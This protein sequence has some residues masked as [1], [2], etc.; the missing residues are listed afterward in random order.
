MGGD[1]ENPNKLKKYYDS[2]IQ[3]ASK[4]FAKSKEAISKLD[5][6]KTFSKFNIK[7]V[8]GNKRFNVKIINKKRFLITGGALAVVLIAITYF[9]FAN[10]AFA[11]MINGVE[12]AKVKD[13]KLV[14]EL[15]T[16]L[17]QS[18]EK[19]N[20]AEVA[21]TNQISYQKIN[22]SKK[23]L[24]EGK[25]LE[26][27]LKKHLDYQVECAVIYADDKPIVT[28]K[29]KD[30]AERVLSGVEQYF[31][32]VTETSKIKE[33]SFSEKVEIKEEFTDIS[34]AMEVEDA[35][36]YII[37]G[38]SEVRIH[39]V[40]AGESFWSISRKYDISLEDLQKANPT[41]NPEKIK[42]G[43]ELNLVVPKSLISVKTIEEVTYT[44]KI[45][46]E[47]KLELS[48]S[49]Y[50]DQ[51]QVRVK[52]QYGEKEVKA[53]VIKINGIESERVILSENII[54]EP[55]D[56][57]LV[58][59]TKDPPPKKGTGTFSTPTRGTITSRYGYRWGRNHN[60]IDIAAPI[61]TPVK[62][63]DGGEVI[64]AGTSGGYGK[65]IKIDH[66]AGFVT[67]YGHL[68]KISVKV[69]QK[70]YKGQV[71]GAVGNTGNSTGPHLHFE[72][73][74]NGSP[75]NPSKYL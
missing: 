71:I 62:A 29:T 36:N 4:W 28:L 34:L 7:S 40:E 1:G 35:Q 44:D 63:A 43:Q 18:Y 51:T 59:G 48:S 54:K 8:A 58:K 50:K 12:I 16:V 42:I 27:E 21:F 25:A 61:G 69:G 53:E 47:Q 5:L 24:L 3:Q 26:E 14:E 73:R 19:K 45:P 30:E 49:L 11:V 41:A 15:L 13:K 52:G 10:N 56:Q 75:V 2:L 72:I 17:K 23:E 66:G 65:M 74:K 64:F 55:K 68:S 32:Q 20:A 67:Y 9:A 60:G 46:Y 22:A 33:K 37:N 38:T 31:T 70:V 39:K 57:I 6:K